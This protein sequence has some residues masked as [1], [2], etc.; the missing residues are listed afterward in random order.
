MQFIENEICQHTKNIWKS[1]LGLD[2]EPIQSEFKASQGGDRTLIGCV[3][4][5]GAWEG[6]V[7]ILC[8][9]ALAQKCASIMFNISE[10][11][12]S[13]EEIQDSL[14]ELANITG[15]NLKAL[16]PET[17]YL[18]LPTVAFT[19]AIRIPGSELLTKVTFQCGEA[20][21][22]VTLV[23]RAEVAKN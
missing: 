14:G 2:V 8:P 6:T 5:T 9:M 17:C 13:H 7:A 4:I 3:H 21:F 18:S 22:M 11:A 1:T 20:S 16:L 19:E 10:E 23:K 15:G 12:A